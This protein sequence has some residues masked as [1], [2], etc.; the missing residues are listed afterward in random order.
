ML[1]LCSLSLL[2]TNA[3][4]APCHLLVYVC[5]QIIR[6]ANT[7]K[8][9]HRTSFTF[10]PLAVCTAFGRYRNEFWLQEL[11]TIPKAV[12]LVHKNDK[13]EYPDAYLRCLESI[14]AEAA[15]MIKEG[16]VNSIH[17]GHHGVPGEAW[18]DISAHD[19]N[20]EFML[21]APAF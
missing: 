1:A 6:K 20:H 16:Q 12:K 4:R 7:G 10:K 3:R 19:K 21:G 15:R 17:I 14:K 11:S 5:P 8:S 13:T 18:P 2:A 9:L